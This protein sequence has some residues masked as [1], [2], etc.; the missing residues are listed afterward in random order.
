MTLR[1]R[2]FAYALGTALAACL[3]TV[4]VGAGL[5]RRQ[6]AEQRL[7]ALTRQ[8]E[9]LAAA[10]G[11]PVG[12]HVYRLGPG[13]AR[14][15]RPRR[16]ALVLAR[17]AATG[18]ATGEIS[19]GPARLLYAARPTPD[20]RIVLV[21]PSGLAFA[22]WRPFL[23]SLILAGL[24]GAAL[25]GLSAFLLARRLTRPIAALA[26]AT[27]RLTAGEAGVEVVVEGADELAQLGHAFN[28]M[29]G[30]L[31]AAR[32]EQRRFL[33]S[34]SHELKTPL[35]SIRGYGEALLDGAV[36]PSQAGEVVV[37]E[38]SRLE[39]LVSDLLDL[40]RVGH[41]SFA[42]ERVELDLGELVARA[43]E[44]HQPRAAELSVALTASS[45]GAAPALGD[46]DRLL[47]AVSNLIENALRVTPAGGAV[48]VHA[49]AGAMT[50]TDTG[51]GLAA[52]ELPHA[53]ERFYLH[54]R[55]RSERE[56]GSGLGLALVRELVERMGG[57]VAVE[58]APGQGATFTLRLPS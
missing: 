57:E 43:V 33:E 11:I 18:R 1:R 21:R 10:P 14:Q 36:A 51:P 54:D 6:V 19:V 58:S 2:V 31:Q 50:V 38:A 15:L 44:R 53:F 25:A 42:V 5:V 32:D 9:F 41:S 35:T 28:Q 46:P 20:G 52:E 55:Y 24:G 56:V 27:R 45:D 13:G 34:V 39:R 48:R 16:A 12:R 37:A 7:A 47:Q 40:A 17:V 29:A 26:R 8:A 22:E 3:L 30:G 4:A 23:E 49:A